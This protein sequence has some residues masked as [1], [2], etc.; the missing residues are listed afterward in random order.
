MD[1]RRKRNSVTKKDEDKNAEKL[2]QREDWRVSVI[3]DIN[4]FSIFLVWHDN[5][6][7]IGDQNVF[8]IHNFRLGVVRKWRHGIRKRMVVGNKNHMTMGEGRQK[9]RDVIYGQP[10]GCFSLNSQNT[11]IYL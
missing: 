6:I 10:R 5:P 3:D 9:L 4:K 11:M 1:F 8:S 7:D 2:W